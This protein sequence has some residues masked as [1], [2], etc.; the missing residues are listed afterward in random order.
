M[1]PMRVSP[2]PRR[3]SHRR[4]GSGQARLARL[5]A[6]PQTTVAALEGE[7][8][9]AVGVLL[10]SSRTTDVGDASVVVCALDRDQSVLTSHRDDLRRPAPRIRLVEV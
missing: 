5:L 9:R 6:A 3:S 8:T 2:S 1:I 10:G 7:S 4:G